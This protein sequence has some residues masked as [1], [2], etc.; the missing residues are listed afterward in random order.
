MTRLAALSL[1]VVVACSPAAESGGTVSEEALAMAVQQKV[2][3]EDRLGAE[4]AALT[5]RLEAAERENADLR[6]RLGIAESNFEDARQIA[7][8]QTAEK[9]RYQRGLDKA[10]GELN[11]VAQTTP[12]PAPSYV[13]PAPQRPR[14]RARVSTLGA[15]YLQIMGD[16]IIVT[17][18]LWNSSEVDAIGRYTVELLSDGRVVSD[19]TSNLDVPAR[20][21]F[22]YS[23]TFHVS[24]SNNTTYSARI[25]LDY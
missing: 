15:P 17:G 4:V 24:L 9:L 5:V 1:L 3:V 14:E 2:E 22:A 12:P 7:Q 16:S 13:P 8:E 23:E 10:V 11:R 25:R 21:D 19:R 18:K 6:S 20:T